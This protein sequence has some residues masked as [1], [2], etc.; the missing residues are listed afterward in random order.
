M[1]QGDQTD[2]LRAAREAPEPREERHQASLVLQKRYRFDFWGCVY[3]D[4]VAMT[5]V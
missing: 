3:F 2:A 4:L 1:A 5:P